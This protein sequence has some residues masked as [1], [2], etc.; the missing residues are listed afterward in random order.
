MRWNNREDIQTIAA[1]V[2]GQERGEQSDG[3]YKECAEASERQNETYRAYVK[4]PTR[5]RKG[6][7]QRYKNKIRGLSLC[8]QFNIKDQ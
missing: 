3:Y 6:R 7:Y 4:R 2:L 1:S 8:F 5:A